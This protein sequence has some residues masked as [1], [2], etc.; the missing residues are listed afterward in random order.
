VIIAY[1]SGVR[2]GEVLNLRR[3]CVEHDTANDLWL[4]NGRHYQNA[5]DADGNKPPARAPRRGPWVVVD[6]RW[7]HRELVT[8]V[9]E[10]LAPPIRHQR[11]R[12]E[13]KRLQRILDAHEPENHQ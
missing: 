1:L 2:P 13:L 6:I 4:M 5:V 7:R 3:G 11:E 9:D 10:P 8:V 12:H